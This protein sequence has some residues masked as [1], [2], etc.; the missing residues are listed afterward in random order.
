MPE[1]PNEMLQLPG[2]TKANY[3]KYGTKLLDITVKYSADKFGL[4]AEEQDKIEEFSS[5]P[6]PSTSMASRSK[7]TSASKSRVTKK[8]AAQ[9]GSWIN[10]DSQE[11]QYFNNNAKGKSKAAPKRKSF[12]FGTKPKYKKA[13]TT[14][15]K[16]RKKASP[17]IAA[18]ASRKT[19]AKPASKFGGSSSS[20][21]F[22]PMPMPR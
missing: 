16:G 8:A 1:T 19:A 3:D 20:I 18:T 2:V 10:V 4:L 15:A 9:E 12:T 11:S 6:G 17:K 22:M 5:Q 14:A 7:N 21:G 13:S